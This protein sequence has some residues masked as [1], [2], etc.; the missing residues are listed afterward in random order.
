MLLSMTGFGE[1]RRQT[2]T[3]ALQVELRTVNNRYLKLNVRGPEPYPLWE[4][5]IEKVIRRFIKRGT[6][7]VNL[8]AERQ[9][10]P[11]DFR[12]NTVALRSY[13]DQLE[14]LCRERNAPTQAV[15]LFPQ[16]LAL[17]GVTAESLTSEATWE[18]DWPLLEQ[19]LVE[20]LQRLQQMRQDEGT[21]M[22]Q[23]L[24]NLQATIS[25]QLDGIRRLA[26]LVQQT[27]RQRLFDRVR[28]AVQDVGVGVEPEHLIR[29]VAVFAERSDISEEITRL[30]SHLQQFAQTIHQEN[31]L[32]GRKLEFITQEMLRETNTI[33]SKAGDVAISRHVVE[34]KATLE[35]IREL[36]QNI[37]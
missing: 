19:V 35:K 18:H 29:E 9:Y 7:L 24:L 23:E 8:R 11:S 20:A 37:E 15:H 31:D 13:L 36:I 12:L 2:E 26:P 16:V 27:Y 21:A 3:L 1:S 34:I 28:Q 32:P 4:A 22:A 10:R 6:V 30:D 17:P 14:Q 33:G 5:E 25:V